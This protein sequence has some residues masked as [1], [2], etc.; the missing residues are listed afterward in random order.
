[1]PSLENINVFQYKNLFAS[2]VKNNNLEQYTPKV[3][4]N[5]SDIIPNKLYIIKLYDGYNGNGM[6]I[7]NMITETNFTN[8]I[9]QE[10]IKNTKEYTSQIVAKMEK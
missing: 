6:L 9:I 4:N 3:C 7:T 10:Y 1:M 8:N 2:Y 5:I